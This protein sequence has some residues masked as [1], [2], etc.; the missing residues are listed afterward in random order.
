MS[1][2]R[3]VFW[4]NIEYAK[5]AARARVDVLEAGF[6]SA[7][8]L[9]FLIVKTIAEEISEKETSPIIAA[10]CQLRENQFESSIRSLEPAIPFRKARLHTYL[11]VDPQLMDALGDYGKDYKKIIED[12]YRL[13]KYAVKQ[14]VEVEF[15][16][17]GYSRLGENFSFVTDAIRAAIDGGATI[18]NCPDTIG[19]ACKLQGKDYFVENMN[20]H[21][22]IMS[23]EFPDKDIT[24]SAHCHNDFGLALENSINAVLNGPATQIE[25]CFN[26]VGERAGNVSLEQVV[27]YIKTFAANF[28]E[29]KSFYTNIKSEFLQNIS[30]FVS[31]NMLQ[32]QPHWPITGE[33]AAKHSSGGHTN[34]IIKNPLSYQPFDPK[35]IGNNISFLFG[36]F[37]GGNHAKDIIEKYGYKCDDN[38][39]AK[40]AQYI[41]DCH[42]ERRKGITDRELIVTYLNYRKP[43]KVEKFNYTKL[44]N[45]SRLEIFG[46]FFG[47]NKIFTFS[48]SSA[49]SALTTL[50]NAVL[51]HMPKVKIE[52]YNSQ[53]ISEG[54][55]SLS[56]SKTIIDNG[57]NCLFT[58]VGEDI[59]IE[60][61]A[62]K[63]FIDAVNQAYIKENFSQNYRGL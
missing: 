41:K 58:G 30:N 1:R 26:G 62:L 40:I 12:V 60:I 51:E 49:G 27:M 5:F 4:K 28:D 57:D 6:P 14:G 34:A 48:T 18:I 47:V 17:E 59:D 16:A 10:L 2:S 39:K 19:G 42:V 29:N 38:E 46:D 24:W 23:K 56:H 53:S 20:K 7:S 43:I 9:D 8:K 15:T 37:S 13:V 33:N 32:R 21:A 35:E 45:E 31:I 25:G 3:N 52:K 54:V 11:P 36:P 63:S 22:N 50:Y 44:E 55:S 61:A